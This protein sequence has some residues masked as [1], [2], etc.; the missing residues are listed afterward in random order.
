MLSVGET[1]LDFREKFNNRAEQDNCFRAHLELATELDCPVAVHCV[2]AWGKMLEIFHDYPKPKKILHAYGG[3]VE[4]IPGLMKLNCWFSFGE[5]VMNPK[6]KRAREAAAAVPAERL[7][8]ETDS[9]GEPEKLMPV[10]RAVAELRGV[11]VEEIAARTFEN[12]QEL[13]LTG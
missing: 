11:S 2:Q 12:S 9:E 7:L 8:I 3:S 10:A 1:G 13:F 6:F 4:L 5:A